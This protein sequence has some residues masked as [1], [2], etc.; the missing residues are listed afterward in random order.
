[1]CVEISEIFDEFGIVVALRDAFGFLQP[2]QKEEQ[3]Y[4]SLRDVKSEVVVGDLVRYKER[5]GVK[6]VGKSV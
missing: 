2:L 4:F 3:I 1:M 5:T 6:A